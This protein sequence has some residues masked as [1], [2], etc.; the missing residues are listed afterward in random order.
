MG[1]LLQA[2]GVSRVVVGVAGAFEEKQQVETTALY[3]GVK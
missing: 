3:F 2:N 1:F